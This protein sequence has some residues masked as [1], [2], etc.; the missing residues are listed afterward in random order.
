MPT[1]YR[2]SRSN[3]TAPIGGHNTP[4]KRVPLQRSNM[5]VQK[6]MSRNRTATVTT[7]TICSNDEVEKGN[8]ADFRSWRVGLHTKNPITARRHLLHSMRVTHDFFLQQETLLDDTTPTQTNISTMLCI[9]VR[10][11]VETNVAGLFSAVLFHHRPLT[12]GD[13]GLPATK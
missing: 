4:P 6:L 11:D 12:R 9:C 10:P 3:S 5:C 8:E 7:L 13:L 2:C 1:G